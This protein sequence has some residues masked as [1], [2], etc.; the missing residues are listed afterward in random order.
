MID[1]FLRLFGDL[2]G[3]DVENEIAVLRHHGIRLGLIATA[4]RS[5]IPP[6]TNNGFPSRISAWHPKTG[7]RR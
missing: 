3:D 5:V 2:L 6:L 4:A 1:A 7:W